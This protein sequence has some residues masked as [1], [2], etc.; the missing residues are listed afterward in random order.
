MFLIT[1]TNSKGRRRA[2]TATAV[3]AL[4][5]QRDMMDAG[6]APVVT[7]IKGRMLSFETLRGRARLEDRPQ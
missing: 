2:C 3:Q 1:A 6:L 4:R 7:D 5:Q